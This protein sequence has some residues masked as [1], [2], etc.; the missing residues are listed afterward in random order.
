MV[1]GRGTSGFGAVT[2]ERAD[3]VAALCGETELVGAEV[4][5]ASSCGVGSSK[6]SDRVAA[7]GCTLERSRVGVITTAMRDSCN[8]VDRSW[9]A[10]CH[11][12]HPFI[13]VFSS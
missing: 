12:E 9:D 8:G 1:L 5:E 2:S 7:L 13:C 11:V 4:I 6:P 10:Q 3:S